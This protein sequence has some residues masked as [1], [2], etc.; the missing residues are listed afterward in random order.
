[1]GTLTIAKN[2]TQ[3]KTDGCRGSDNCPMDGV[4]IYGQPA[5]Y[6]ARNALTSRKLKLESPLKSAMGF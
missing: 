1:M 5:A 4:V 2:E 6:A 3:Q